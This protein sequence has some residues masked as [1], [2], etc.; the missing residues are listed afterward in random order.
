MK[1]CSFRR[2]KPR[3][4]TETFFCVHEPESSYAFSPCQNCRLC[5]LH[6]NPNNRERAGPMIQFGSTKGHKFRNGYRALLNCPVDCQT[7][8]LIYVMTS[9]CK[10]FEYIGETTQRLYDRLRCKFLLIC[11]IRREEQTCLYCHRSSTS[12]QSDVSRVLT[13]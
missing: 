12:I 11:P 1:T 10:S 6:Y 9:P 7:N 2:A 4:R 13:W 8:N 3:S 5:V